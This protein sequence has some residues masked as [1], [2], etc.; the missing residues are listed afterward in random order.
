M[1]IIR[2]VRYGV[3]MIDSPKGRTRM[4]D[5]YISTEAE[6]VSKNSNSDLIVGAWE[7]GLTAKTAATVK[8]M[9]NLD[10]AGFALQPEEAAIIDLTHLLDSY[11]RMAEE[12]LLDEQPPRAARKEKA[13]A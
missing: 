10:R 7:N 6:I 5:P 13:A 3:E 1:T 4:L 9:Q 11:D 8:G 12:L 2:R